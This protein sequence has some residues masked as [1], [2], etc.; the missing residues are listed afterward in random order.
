ML[1]IKSN[2][3]AHDRSAA[4]KQFTLQGMRKHLHPALEEEMPETQHPQVPKNNGNGLE[5]TRIIKESSAAPG[6]SS[7]RD[8]VLLQSVVGSGCR[9]RQIYRD[10]GTFFRKLS[11]TPILPTGM[12]HAYHASLKECLRFSKLVCYPRGD[13]A[14]TLICPLS[15]SISR[16]IIIHTYTYTYAHAHIRVLY[17]HIHTCTSFANR[18]CVAGRRHRGNR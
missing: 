3:D 9:Q 1:E 15:R 7:H 18:S 12:L 11:A 10:N 5:A 6:V 14:P 8:D 16:A 13:N 17:S 2:G 4:G